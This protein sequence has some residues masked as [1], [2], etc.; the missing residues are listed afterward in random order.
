MRARFRPWAV[1]PSLYTSD[2]SWACS[3]GGRVDGGA[4]VHDHPMFA[5]S[6]SGVAPADTRCRI[7]ILA[8]G[9]QERCCFVADLRDRG[10]MLG[11][12]LALCPQCRTSRARG[13][14]G[15]GFGGVL[16]CIR[17]HTSSGALRLRGGRPSGA[18]QSRQ[19]RWHKKFPLGMQLYEVCSFLSVLIR[20][21]R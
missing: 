19:E 21:P 14:G 2:A 5:G 3:S 12:A 17:T 11:D 4:R 1:Q 15:V 16:W 10:H 9:L 8:K 6:V 18:S 13:T 7:R 20:C